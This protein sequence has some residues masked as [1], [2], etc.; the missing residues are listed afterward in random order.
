MNFVTVDSRRRVTLPKE[1][2]VTA[3]QVMGVSV[4]GDHAEFFPVKVLPM[5]EYEK[6]LEQM[7]PAQR[8]ALS[9]VTF[10]PNKA[11]EAAMLEARKG[12]RKTYPTTEA[13]FEAL[14]A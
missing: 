10:V 12:G 2:K 14:N 11:T 7:S 8:E 3:G 4:V 13:L 5:E 6:V 9:R 1:L